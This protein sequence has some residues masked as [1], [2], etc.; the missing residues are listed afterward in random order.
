MRQQ[1]QQ[2]RLILET[3]PDAMIVIDEAGL[4]RSFS[5]AAERSFGYRAEQVLGRN[6]ALLMPPPDSARHDSYIARYLGT[7][8]RRIIGIGR[9]VSAR[10]ADGTIFPVQLTV[11]E[12]AGPPGQ[13]LFTGFVQDLSERRATE[14]RLDELRA[15]LLHRSRLGDMG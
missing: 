2:L 9:I 15:E 14:A 7:G 1:E 8:E 4:V 10:R 3:V 13:R 12:V 6:V 5:A 11:G